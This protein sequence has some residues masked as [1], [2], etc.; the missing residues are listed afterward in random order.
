MK[1]SLQLGVYWVLLLSCCP[2]VLAQNSETTDPCG[3]P[4]M[5]S[6]LWGFVRGRVIK[7]EDGDTLTLI[8][9]GSGLRKVN[10]IGIDAPERG[11]SF[12]KAARL[13]LDSLVRDKVVEVWVNDSDW[14]WRGKRRQT[15]AQLTG[16]VYLPSVDMLDVNLVLVQSGM[17][18]HEE[19]EPY[20]VS[21]H[22]ECHY[23]RAESDACAGR[24][25]LWRGRSKT[26]PCS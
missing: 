14:S 17:A 26:M 1:M 18:R 25:G 7:V 3:D 8:V 5:E 2:I 10:L 20:S 4:A 23:V 11:Q 15:P 21:N 12:A 13:L 22:T 19:T 6:Q 9:E 16:V 24:R